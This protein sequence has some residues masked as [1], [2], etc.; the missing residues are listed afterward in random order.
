M[1]LTPR[2]KRILQ[3]AWD[4][5]RQLGHNYIG[6]EHLPL[7]IIREGDGVAI[8]VLKNL[9]IDVASIRETVLQQLKTRVSWE[10]HEMSLAP[11]AIP[12]SY[13]CV[14]VPLSTSC[15]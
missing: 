12:E 2:A 6:P 3:L 5:A 7:G 9:K 1:P 11:F 15:V 14:L 4:E 13:A 8:K 10:R